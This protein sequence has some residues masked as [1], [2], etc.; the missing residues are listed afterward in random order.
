MF[1]AQQ[2]A[3]ASSLALLPFP[4]IERGNQRSLAPWKL[5]IVLLLTQ[6]LSE[7]GLVCFLQIHPQP[8]T[9]NIGHRAYGLRQGIHRPGKHQPNSSTAQLVWTW[10]Y[11]LGQWAIS[12]THFLA[13]LLNGSGL[14]L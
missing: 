7:S 13:P 11:F 4:K 5:N 9:D 6:L 3:F 14:V 1:A 10:G 2:P 12:G 8:A